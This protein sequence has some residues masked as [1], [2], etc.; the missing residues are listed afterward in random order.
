MRTLSQRLQNDQTLLND[1][2]QSQISGGI[3]ERVDTKLEDMNKKHYLPHH[4]VV[5]PSKDSTKVR[6]VI[7]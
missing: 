6:I 4:P 1:I 7:C 3:I 2:I 5:T